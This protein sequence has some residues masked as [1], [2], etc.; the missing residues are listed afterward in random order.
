MCVCVCP[1]L[2]FRQGHTASTKLSDA[3]GRSALLLLLLLYAPPRDKRD[4]HERHVR[5]K[6][7]VRARPSWGRG[8]CM[9]SGSR[10]PREGPGSSA[11][12]AR[13]RRR[14]SSGR[15]HRQS[16]RATRKRGWLASRGVVPHMG[17]TRSSFTTHVWHL[18]AS[19]STLVAEVG[20]CRWP[21]PIARARGSPTPARAPFPHPSSTHHTRPH[22]RA[23]VGGCKATEVDQ[24]PA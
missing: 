12:G 2:Y 15:R 18:S 11:G 21:L 14:R 22:L 1:A 17:S 4:P 7:I 9:G 23:R 5:S 8:S 13:P 10:G 20:G 16:I 6:S 24:A 3:D 19:H